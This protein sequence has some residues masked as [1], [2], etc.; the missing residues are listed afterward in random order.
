[1]ETIIGVVAIS[2]IILSVGFMVLM[3]VGQKKY[4]KYDY[5]TRI[6][7]ML[8]APVFKNFERLSKEHLPPDVAQTILNEGDSI[9]ERQHKKTDEFINRGFL[10][11]CRETIYLALDRDP[12]VFYSFHDE[13]KDWKNYKI[14]TDL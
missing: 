9:R 12:T 10:H 3:S 2:L 11:F 13:V 7:S 1:M 6:I 4:E 8:Y 14:P 5:G